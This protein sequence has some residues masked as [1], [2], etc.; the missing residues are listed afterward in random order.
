[1]MGA[2]QEAEPSRARPATS[3][4]AFDDIV[5]DDVDDV[6]CDLFGVC[7]LDLSDGTRRCSPRSHP[8]RPRSSRTTDARRAIRTPRVAR[9]LP[10]PGAPEFEGSNRLRDG[11]CCGATPSPSRTTPAAASSCWRDRSSWA[12]TNSTTCNTRSPAAWPWGWTSRSPASRT[13]SSTT[14]PASARSRA[15]S[16][17]RYVPSRGVVNDLWGRLMTELLGTIVTPDGV[18]QLNDDIPLLPGHAFVPSDLEPVVVPDLA[19]LLER[20]DRARPD[21]HRS[22]RRLGRARRPDEL[23]HQPV[24][25]PP[26]PHAAVRTTVRRRGRGRDRSRTRARA[27]VRRRRGA[28]ARRDPNRHSSLGRRAAVHGRVRRAAAHRGRRAGRRR[29][30]RVLRAES[31]NDTQLFRRL[32]ATLVGAAAD[33]AL[34][35][36]SAFANQNEDW[37]AWADPDLVR[38]GQEVFGAYGPQLGMGLFMASLPADYAFAKGVQVLVATTWPRVTRNAATSRPDR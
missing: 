11:F 17:T 38:A 7:V 16:T 13:A 31:A 30:Q 35:G 14:C 26:S 33:T 4:A 3:S 18:M 10:V 12:R 1:M 32:A 29:R 37:P 9:C 5:P 34:P 28:G 25:V 21:G 6:L 2:A 22:R 20:F 23:H 36:I 8:R 15:R 19:A 27:A 24:P